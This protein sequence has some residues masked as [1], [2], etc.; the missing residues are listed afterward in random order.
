MADFIMPGKVVVDEIV[1]VKKE[2]QQYYN[3]SGNYHYS[4]R[5]ITTAHHFSVSEDFVEIVKGNEKIEYSV[6]RIFNEV[7][8]YRLLTTEKK[9]VYSLRIISALLLP[10]M[11]IVAIGVA[12]RNK[13]KINILVF[14]LQTLLI[15]NLIHLII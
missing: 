14:V 1:G 3:A 8:W 4:C 11:T 10:L 9:D 7:N 6:S 15:A 12:Y 2:R 5:V 13:K